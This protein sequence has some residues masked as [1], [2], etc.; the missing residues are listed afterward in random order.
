MPEPRD[1]IVSG[2]FGCALAALAFVWVDAWLLF[3]L[4]A[5]ALL[6]LGLALGFGAVRLSL[7]L[8]FAAYALLFGGM[9]WLGRPGEPLRLLGGLPTP[10]SLLVYGIWPMPLLAALL[11]ALVFRSSVLPEDKLQKFLAEHGRREPRR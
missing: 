11:Y 7:I 3:G 4:A 9:V 2:L 10:T 1:R 5:F 8:V 6:V